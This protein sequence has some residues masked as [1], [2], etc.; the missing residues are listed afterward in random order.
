MN[1]Y[2]MIL[3]DPYFLIAYILVTVIGI[4]LLNIPAAITG[5]T[6]LVREYYIKNWKI[7]IP[8]DLLLVFA[9]FAVAEFI[10]NA[11]A[12][13]QTSKRLLVLVAV[14][15]AISGAF[16]WWFT[17]QPQT[18]AFFSRWFYR[19]GW[20]AVLYDVILLGSIYIIYVSLS[21]KYKMYNEII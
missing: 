9:Y 12:I 1:N 20:Q 8:L 3:L 6:T 14:T 13:T 16:C 4:Y 11:T 5:E 10:W 2:N 21:K 7:N 17:S 18:G 19:V 15:I